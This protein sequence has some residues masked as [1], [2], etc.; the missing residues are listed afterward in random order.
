[1]VIFFR[2]KIQLYKF[3]CWQPTKYEKL[4]GAENL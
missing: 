1:M 4:K 2:Y 3:L